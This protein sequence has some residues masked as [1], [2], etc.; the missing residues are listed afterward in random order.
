MFIITM[1]NYSSID[2]R[3]DELFTPLRAVPTDRQD[4]PR[5]IPESIFARLNSKKSSV[6]GAPAKRP[7]NM[8]SPNISQIV[9]E[10]IEKA[11]AKL[12][13]E[14]NVS[15]LTFEDGRSDTERNNYTRKLAEDALLRFVPR[16]Y[17]TMTFKQ[18]YRENYK[19]MCSA[20]EWI[21]RKDP[22]VFDVYRQCERLKPVWKIF[23]SRMDTSLR[24]ERRKK[25]R[26][27]QASAVVR[28]QSTRNE[29]ARRQEDN[30]KFP[31]LSGSKYRVDSRLEVEDVQRRIQPEKIQKNTSRNNNSIAQSSNPRPSRSFSRRTCPEIE[32]GLGS[33]R[34]IPS[35][36][37]SM[38]EEE[39]DHEI[40]GRNCRLRFEKRER[41]EN[42]DS[43]TD[44]DEDV[45]I[46]RARRQSVRIQ[47][48]RCPG[49]FGHELHQEREKSN[50]TSQIVSNRNHL[51][52]HDCRE[53]IENEGNQAEVLSTF[54]RSRD[55]QKRSK[56]KRSSSGNAT[57][58]K[59]TR[60]HPKS[61]TLN[62][63]EK[64]STE[65]CSDSDLEKMMLEIQQRK[66][67]K[68]GMKKN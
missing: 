51:A 54:R 46:R 21:I 58:Y 52:M 40:V 24:N 6:P 22:S 36:Q 9:R 44:S 35:A 10:F 25:K 30:D 28:N 63:I 16:Q 55:I 67:R 42:I 43:F 13:E 37:N 8:R 26:K 62:H 53:Q 61:V 27:E 17:G 2:Q 5:L 11:N 57:S 23:E 7:D 14:G 66:R 56:R 45:D 12:L 18:C 33:T 39:N 15:Y 20:L 48:E 47:S 19:A 59:D 65:D 68:F 34:G 31:H 32:K 50:T 64:R 49:S 29:A 4:G 1:T 38:D 3:D 41:R 60:G